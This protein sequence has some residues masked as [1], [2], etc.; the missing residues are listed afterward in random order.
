MYLILAY[1]PEQGEEW[2]FHR[3]GMRSTKMSKGKNALKKV[4]NYCTSW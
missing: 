3:E 2:K 4:G 1:E